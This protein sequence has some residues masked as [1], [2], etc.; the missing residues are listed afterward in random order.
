ME[1]DIYIFNVWIY[2][3]KYKKSYCIISVVATFFK[4]N[5]NICVCVNVLIIVG[6]PRTQT[7]SMYSLQSAGV[8]VHL[9]FYP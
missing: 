2:K 5:N 6:N 7:P 3:M 1:N 8:Y 4:E 9:T